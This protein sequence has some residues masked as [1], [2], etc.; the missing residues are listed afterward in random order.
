MRFIVMF[1]TAVCV[2]FLTMLNKFCVFEELVFFDLWILDSGFRIPNS[3]F[4]IRDSGFRFR[5]LD[6]GFRVL[7][8]PCSKHHTVHGHRVSEVISLVL[9]LVLVYYGLRLSEQSSCNY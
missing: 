8:L 9:V 6:S 2:L 4:R 7:G 3:G 5:N 1:V